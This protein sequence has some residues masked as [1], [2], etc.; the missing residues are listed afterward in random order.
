[1]QDARDK[2]RE[3]QELQQQQDQLLQTY[4]RAILAANSRE[5]ELYQRLR[6]KEENHDLE[7][8]GQPQQHQLQV[9]WFDAM[10]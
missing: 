1:M 9:C 3:N 10:E 6:E 7:Q 8:Q 4:Q 5:Q 2:Q